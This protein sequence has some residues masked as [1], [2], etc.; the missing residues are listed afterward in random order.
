M[1]PNIIGLGEVAVDWVAQ[2]DH[3]PKPDE[4]IDSIYQELFPGGVTANYVTACSRLGVST[5]FIGAAGDDNYGNFLLDDFRAEG[6]DSS[7]FLLKE[8][9]KSPVNF[10]L[11]VKETGE[12]IIIQSPYMQST[13]IEFTEIDLNYL[14]SAKLIHTTAIHLDTT[15]EVLKLAKANDV[16][17]SLD[18][19]SQI[20]VRGWDALAPVISLVDILMPN[21]EGARMLSQKDEIDDVGQFFLE[22][23]VKIIVI[24]LGGEG[25]KIFTESEIFNVPA[26]PIK[27]VD[28][29]GA[30]DTFTGAFDI[31]HTINGWDLFESARFANAA[32][33][34]KCLKLGARTGMPRFK[35]V[36]DFIEK[37]KD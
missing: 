26:F 21:K 18:L 28:T 2:V 20:A 36:Q 33:A 31:C 8:A 3:F 1:Q 37:W 29:T 16:T 19:E 4:K 9:K 11:V 6:V 7:F 13:R 5:G 17:V 32:A 24:T 27:P 30:G 25:C 34:I 22:Q 23:G 35:E 12:K 14:A 15:L 10:I